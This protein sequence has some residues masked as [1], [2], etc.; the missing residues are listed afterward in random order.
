MEIEMVLA[1]TLNGL[2]YGA[3]LFLV[4]SGLTLT[5]GLMRT[6][7]LA[8]GAFYLLGG[9]L[10][11]EVLNTTGSYWAGLGAAMVAVG[12]LGMVYGM[13]KVDTWTKGYY[14]KRLFLGVPAAIIGLVT[15]VALLT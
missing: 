4:A 7:N 2:S 1:R 13:L 3:L 9:Y 6:L 11:L 12:L 14:T 8:H 15:L 5:F 10:A